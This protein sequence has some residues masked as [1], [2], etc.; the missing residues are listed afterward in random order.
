MNCVVN[1][2]FGALILAT[3]MPLQ[4]A[5]LQQASIETGF[6]PCT[7]N[8]HCAEGV[9]LMA[10]GDAKKSLQ[11][12]AYSFTSRSVAAALLEAHRRGVDVRVILDKSNMTAKYSSA[13]FL[14]NQGVPV[15]I[16][17][18]Y[19]IMH[20]K[21][22]VVDGANVQT[23]SFNYSKAAAGSNAENVIYIRADK[24]LA[25]KYSG[26]WARLWAES[27]DYSR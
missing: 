23:G 27:S 9:V 12:A 8:V 1:R 22:I 11:V 17:S 6:S 20:N 21:F 4:A 26:E 24:A 25:E 14:A 15:R 5:L 16:N 19:A 10:I 3:V 18:R 2:V 13:T 7:N